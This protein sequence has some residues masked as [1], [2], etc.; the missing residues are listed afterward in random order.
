MG[1]TASRGI[2]VSFETKCGDESNPLGAHDCIEARTVMHGRGTNDVV[3]TKVV[4]LG[5]DCATG[6]PCLLD[7]SGRGITIGEFVCGVLLP[8]LFPGMMALDHSA[9]VNRG[10]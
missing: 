1:L 3:S 9:E 2:A 8:I 4:R 7:E 5:L 10:A 6:E